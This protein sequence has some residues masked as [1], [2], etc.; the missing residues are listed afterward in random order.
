MMMLFVFDRSWSNSS[1]TWHRRYE[2]VRKDL[3][4]NVYTRSSLTYQRTTQRWI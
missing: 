2:T 1:R 4:F 3:I